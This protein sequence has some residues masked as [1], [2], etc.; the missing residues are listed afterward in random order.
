[1]LSCHGVASRVCNFLSGSMVLHTTAFNSL[2]VLLRQAVT[3][4]CVRVFACCWFCCLLLFLFADKEL[5]G[6]LSWV[7]LGYPL[8]SHTT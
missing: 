1:M 2:R 8:S 4:H 3:V 5:M 6:G 7:I